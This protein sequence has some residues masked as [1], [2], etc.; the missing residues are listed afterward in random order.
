[1]DSP[2]EQ[3]DAALNLAEVM[4]LAGEPTRASEFVRQAIEHYERK[5][6]T[7]YVARARHLAAAWTAENQ[8]DRESRKLGTGTASGLSQ[9]A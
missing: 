1:M 3:G 7:A 6:A 4:Y 8:Q 2:R 5:G 9:S